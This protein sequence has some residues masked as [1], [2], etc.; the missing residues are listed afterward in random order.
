MNQSVCASREQ[1]SF[2]HG[3]KHLATFCHF[4]E[5]TVNPSTLFTALRPQQ[6]AARFIITFFFLFICVLL[7]I[8]EQLAPWRCTND[9][10]HFHSISMINASSAGAL[11]KQWL[12]FLNRHHLLGP[13]EGKKKWQALLQ[14]PLWGLRAWMC[15]CVRKVRVL[16]NVLQYVVTLCAYTLLMLIGDF[17]GTLHLLAC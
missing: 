2:V 5:F 12:E 14:T 4:N 17:S 6:S 1:S 8:H 9:Q 15:V 11:S 3:Y 10:C 13:W 16:F 7:C